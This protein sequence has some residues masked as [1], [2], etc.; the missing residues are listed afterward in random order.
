MFIGIGSNLGDRRANCREAR[1]R[2]SELPKTRVVKES[3][4]YESEPHGDAKTWFANSVVEIETEL[5][6]AELL[7]KIL[8]IE[9]TMG[10]KRVK[11]KRWGAR[12]IDLDI[13]FFDM[14]VIDKRNLK[15]PHPR[16]PGR[17]FVLIPLSE[18][19]PQ[20]IHPGLNHSVSELLAKVK[21]SKKVHLMSTSD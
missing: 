15:V 11:G 19:A 1:V 14:E 18:L 20:L 3:S 13:L 6:P 12:V 10:R 5:A 8:A 17:R 7:K 2:L 9:E 16:L 21:D 4:L